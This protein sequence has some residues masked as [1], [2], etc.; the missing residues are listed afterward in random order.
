MGSFRRLAYST[1]HSS[2]AAEWQRCTSTIGRGVGVCELETTP[3]EVLNKLPW[4]ADHTEPIVP[5]LIVHGVLTI[6]DGKSDAH[7]DA[8]AAPFS[9]ATG[10]SGSIIGWSPS[11]AAADTGGIIRA[12]SKE[13]NVPLVTWGDIVAPDVLDAF[14]SQI[15]D[16]TIDCNNRPGM[17]GVKNTTTQENSLML[18]WFIKNCEYGLHMS[19]VRVNNS[20]LMNGNIVMGNAFSAKAVPLVLNNVTDMRPLYGLTIQGLTN[21]KAIAL[22]SATGVAANGIGTIT[23]ISFDSTTFNSNTGPG[24]AAAYVNLSGFPAASSGWNTTAPVT[25]VGKCNGNTCTSLSVQLN[26]GGRNQAAWKGASGYGA[27]LVPTYGIVACGGACGSYGSNETSG[28][29]GTHTGLQ[30]IHLE[31]VGVGLDVTGTADVSLEVVNISCTTTDNT[32]VRIENN[33]TTRNVT[34]RALATNGL[35]TTIDDRIRGIKSM[36]RYKAEYV[37]GTPFP[38]QGPLVDF[39]LPVGLGSHGTAV[40]SLDIPNCP[41]TNGQHLNYNNGA[42]SCGTK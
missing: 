35:L 24:G 29:A 5:R 39:A 34:I 36:D 4:K 15:R 13:E 17:T 12:G 38:G 1:W 41:D 37:T 23:G 42:W 26:P 33:A 8:C 21:G 31:R 25:A 32:C 40:G 7:G 18:N 2:I 3:G 27:H 9:L 30:G 6:C 20:M 16:I 28:P 19:S 10:N 11:K 14:G 22:G